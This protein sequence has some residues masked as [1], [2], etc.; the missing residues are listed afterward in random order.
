MQSRESDRVIMADIGV[1][2]MSPRFQ[3]A[4]L[5][6]GS[7][8]VLLEQSRAALQATA[9]GVGQTQS[10]LKSAAASSASK[11]AKHCSSLPQLCRYVIIF[12]IRWYAKLFS[13]IATR[14]KTFDQGG[15]S[16]TAAASD[17]AIASTAIHVQQI[18]VHRI[19]L[20]TGSEYFR[21]AI[22]TLV[23]HFPDVNGHEPMRPI[24]VL[25]EEDME[26]AHGVLQFLYTQK[27]DRKFSTVP[28][29]MRL[30][31]VGQEE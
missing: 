19:I 4:T 31:M 12:F 1:F 5:L 16:T 25:L 20:T 3:D 13:K 24:I 7:D 14:V 8:S 23:G 26:A 17:K 18:P 6:L 22:S 10:P 15:P 27:L 9:D 30:L 28:Q 21:T 29:L 2:Y 11:P